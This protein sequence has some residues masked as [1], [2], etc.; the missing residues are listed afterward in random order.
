M[1]T[2]I[3]IGVVRSSGKSELVHGEEVLLRDQLDGL[4]ARIVAGT[5]EKFSEVKIYTSDEGVTKRAFFD[6]KTEVEKSAK[7]RAEQQAKLDAPKLAEAKPAKAQ[8]KP[9]K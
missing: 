7:Q 4:K 9:N 3:T 5:D 2:A 1:R 8:P 6:S